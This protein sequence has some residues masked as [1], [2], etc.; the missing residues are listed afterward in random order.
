MTDRQKLPNRRPSVNHRVVWE[1]NES[2]HTFYVSI[3]VDP[4]S[5]K[6]LEVFYADGQKVGHTLQLM[7]Q[8]S[9]VLVSLLLQGGFCAADIAKSLSTIPMHQYGAEPR[10]VPATLIGAIIQQLEACENDWKP[11]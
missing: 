1:T 6:A 7:A 2:S 4:K 8:D 11:A 9:C 5:G 3:G 10:H